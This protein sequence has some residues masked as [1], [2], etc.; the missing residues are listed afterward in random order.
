MTTNNINIL[1]NVPVSIVESAKNAKNPLSTALGRVLI[2]NAYH[3]GVESITSGHD[4]DDAAMLVACVNALR[5]I[6]GVTGY[7]L[8]TS[9]YIDFCKTCVKH[10]EKNGYGMVGFGAFKKWVRCE[11]TTTVTV[12]QKELM[13]MEFKE[14]EKKS[15]AKKL[16]ECTIREMTPEEKAAQAAQLEKKVAAMMEMI[17]RLQAA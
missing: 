12:K 10:G 4:S 5:E 15:R 8:D 17:A 14:K 6:C 1:N 16:D 9:L 2:N 11:H 13:P 7:S 3:Y